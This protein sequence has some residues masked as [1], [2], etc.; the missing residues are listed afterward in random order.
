MTS[1][2]VTSEADA[3]TISVVLA[4]DHAVVRRGLRS[5]LE[6]ERDFEVVAEAGDVDSAIRYARGHKPR[7][8]VLDLT[9]PGSKPPIEAISQILEVSPGT[10]VAVVTMREDLALVRRALSEGAVAYVLK[11]AAEEE[12]IEAIRHAVADDIY[13]T[14]RL[15]A[16]LAMEP[17][18]GGLPDGLSS[19]EGEVLR[20][21][22]LGHTNAEAA[23]DLFLSTR[24]VEAH[25]AVL[26]LKVGCS[27]RAQLVRYAL[28]HRLLTI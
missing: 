27:T 23:E 14:P 4:D 26:Q 16:S 20:L 3:T 12:L 8:L 19:R 22:A 7:V 10:S 9:M 28:K 6:R 15:G 1:E 17:A 18:D 13:L 5:L 25:R 21:L 24:T 2:T 11:E